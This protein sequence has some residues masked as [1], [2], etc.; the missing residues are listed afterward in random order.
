[1]KRLV[2]LLFLIEV[3]SN[4]QAQFFYNP[5]AQ[6]QA[7]QQ[8]YEMGR[9]MMQQQ[10][11]AYDNNPVNAPAITGSALQS[12][13][14]AFIYDDPQEIYD[15]AFE[16]LRHAGYSLDFSNALYWM[17]VVAE[18][19]LISGEDVSDAKGYYKLAANDGH[20]AA[21]TRLRQLERGVSTYDQDYVLQVLRQMSVSAAQ[22]TLPNSGDSGS[23]TGS[24]SG[25]RSNSSTCTKCGG[26]G[27]EYTPY[28]HSAKADS[29]H[30]LGGNTCPICGGLTDHYH[31]RCL[32]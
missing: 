30:N 12:I 20:A 14:S 1:M 3:V 29:Y 7:N 16:R 10:T 4:M 5:Y 13:A 17:G 24:R 15:R 19:D 28:K 6:Q 31:Y 9:R 8:A 18:C 26:T 11:E 27:Y 21:R 32:H 2:I 22:L 25:T 23:S